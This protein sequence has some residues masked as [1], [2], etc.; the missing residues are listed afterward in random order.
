MSYLDN[1]KKEM[2]TNAQYNAG[3]GGD[4]YKMQK[5]NNTF[6]ILTEPKIMF[7]KYN[8]GICYTDCGYQGSPKFLMW[9]LDERDN[10]VKLM[11]INYTSGEQILAL[12]TDVDYGFKGFP[13]PYSISISA[14]DKV[15]T[16]D[17]TY[18]APLPRPVKPLPDNIGDEMSK[19]KP[20][21]EIIERM[22]TNQKEKHVLD[23]TWQKELDRKAALVKELG[24]A[25]SGSAPVKAVDGVDYPEEEIS[26][27]DIPF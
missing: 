13:M 24:E 23:G 3:G 1:V 25:R 12:E 4:W 20:I 15:G 27:D 7:E 14:D 10:V 5:G 22:K 21:S 17:V 26:P 19:R 8:V 16:K 11:K 18:G 9:V 6:R 2:Q